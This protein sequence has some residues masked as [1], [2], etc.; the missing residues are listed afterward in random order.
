MVKDCILVLIWEDARAVLS[1]SSLLLPYFPG[2]VFLSFG[3]VCHFG[4]WDWKLSIYSRGF[5][6][7]SITFQV[8]NSCES[9][10]AVSVSPCWK[11]FLLCPFQLLWQV[12]NLCYDGFSFLQM[13][14][15]ATLLQSLAAIATVI[16]KQQ[17]RCLPFSFLQMDI[18]NCYA[19]PHYR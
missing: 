10:L 14:S 18:T 12:A 19:L 17:S 16:G 7:S 8:G 2:I 3:W 1:S 4:K 6:F 5:C 9:C 15:F 13:V 11:L